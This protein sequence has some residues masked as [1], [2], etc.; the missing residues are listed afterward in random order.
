[1]LKNGIPSADTFARVFRM[2][3]PKGWIHIPSAPRFAS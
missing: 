1:V 3:D 2:L